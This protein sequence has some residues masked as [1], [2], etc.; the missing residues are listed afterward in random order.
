[1]RKSYHNL[2]RGS[3]RA[4]ALQKIAFDALA[5]GGH[6]LKQRETARSSAR[7]RS[8]VLSADRVNFDT[9]H[10]LSRRGIQCAGSANGVSRCSGWIAEVLA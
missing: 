5:G 1:V 10:R 4:R 2:D 3:R 8:E 7:A 9:V 6:L